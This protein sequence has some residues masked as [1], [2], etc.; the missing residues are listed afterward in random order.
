MDA[1]AMSP[2][3]TGATPT[4]P[5]LFRAAAAA[6][7]TADAVYA[8]D[9]FRSWERWRTEADALTRFLQESGI[10]PGDV[11]AVH[12]PNCWEFLTI[13]IAVAAAGA[14]LLPL[15]MALGA[16]EI[17]ALLARTGAVAL[18]VDADR[19]RTL[20]PALT[21][22]F[23]SLRVTLV[24]GIGDSSSGFAST[25]E[26]GDGTTVDGRALD[27]VDTE[28]AGGCC[29]FEDVV[30][31]WTGVS[32]RPVDVRP[33]DR[34]VLVPSSGTTSLRPKI[35]VHTH[36]SLIANAVAVAADAVMRADDTL[37]AAGP[38]THAFGLL[39]VHLSLVAGCRQALLPG[40]DPSAA[41]RLAGRSAATVLFAAPAQ[42]RDLLREPDFGTGLREIRVSGAAV[43]ASLVIDA[44]RAFGTS[45][46]A[47]WGMSE[48]GAGLFT[49]PDDPDD[50]AARGVGRPVTGAQARVVTADGAVC[51]PGETGELQFRSDFRCREYLGD[52]ELTRAALT[53]DGW[54]RTGDRATAHPDGSITLRGRDAEVINVGGQKFV[55]PEVETLLDD[56]PDLDRVAIIGRPDDRLGEY[57]CLVA[58]LRSPGA[59]VTLAGIAAHLTAKGV[60][61]YRIPAELVILDRLPYTPTGK[62]ARARL[63]EQLEHRTA[64]A[65]SIW[66]RELGTLRPA[67]RRSRALELVRA[68]ARAVV[69]AADQIAPDRVFTDYGLTSAGAVRLGTAL[70]AATGL[71]ITTTAAYDH[72]TP[73]LLAAHLTIL[74]DSPNSAAVL[75]GSAAARLGSFVDET[76]VGPEPVAVSHESAGAAQKP[77]AGESVPVVP[78][79]GVVVHDSART[80]L[81]AAADDPVVVIGI[82]CRVPGGVSSPDEFWE[83]LAAGRETIGD[84]PDDRGW[85]VDPDARYARRGSFL[86]ATRFDPGFFGISPREAATMDPQQR[87]LLETSWEAIEH[88]RI[89]PVS[90]RGSDTGVFAGVMTS[91]YLPRSYEVVTGSDPGMMTGN[92]GG[93]ASGRIAYVL[94]LHG[95]AI[96]VDTACSSGL[97]ALHLAVRSLRY[98]ECTL[99][100]AAGAAVL[101]TPV[102]F[103][104][105]AQ[106]N[107]LAADG[108]CK[109]F[110][111]A[112]D[113]TGWG[114]GVGVLVL[115]RLSVARQA[116]HRI[117]GIVRGSA[118]NSDGTSNGLTAP[119]GPAQQR[120]IHR[121]LAD[122]GLTTADVDVLEAHG[123]GTTLGDPIEANAVLATYGRDRAQPLLL[124]SL[125]SNIGH[126]QAAAGILGTIKMLLALHHR[127]VP[128]TLHVDSATPHAHWAAGSVRLATTAT[129]WPAAARPARASVSAFGI[130]GT[131][132]HVVLEAAPATLVPVPATSAPVTD[133]TAPVTDG[134][135]PAGGGAAPASG[136]AEPAGGGTASSAGGTALANGG[137]AP[138]RGAA[139]SAA[140]VAEGPTGIADPANPLLPL[141]VSAASPA[142]LAA[143]ADRI[144]AL[145]DTGAAAVDIGWSLA[146]TRTGF[147]HRAV[148]FGADRADLAALAAG[149]TGYAVTGRADVR[150]G[151]VFVCPGHGTQWAGMASALSVESPVFAA[152][153]DECE[154]AIRELA[155][156]S[157]AEVL[158]DESALSRTEF[159]QPAVFAITVAL[160]RLWQW[161]GVE[162]DAVI[163]HSFGEIA[164]AHLAGVLS[165][166]EAI[167]VVVRRGAACAGLSGRMLSVQSPV[168]EVEQRLAG[169]PGITVAARNSDRV[170]VVSGAAAEIEALLVEYRQAGVVVHPVAI[171]FASHSAHVE[172]A[173]DRLL[174]ELAGLRPRPARIPWYSTVTGSV[175]AGPEADGAYWYDNLRNPV[176]F[177][178]TVETSAAGGFRCFVEVSPHPV[179]ATA[180]A[181]TVGEA[182][183][184]LPTL[185]RRRGGTEQFANG[186]A[187]GYVRGL[188]VRWDRCFGDARTIDLPTY[189][190][191]RDRYWLTPPRITRA[192]AESGPVPSAEGT[193]GAFRTE[194][195]HLDLTDRRG[196]L[197]DLIR[198][199]AATL[200]GHPDPAAIEPGHRFT[201]IGFDSLTAME[202]HDSINRITGL[203]LPL[204]T[205]F[206]ADTPES[207]A[208]L[209]LSELGDGIGSAAH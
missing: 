83:L 143:Q 74:L 205:I 111:A 202:L 100:L 13:H 165:L 3:V 41:R 30:R 23:D 20:L 37:I 207:L 107:G 110:A 184:V 40:W 16:Y 116:G 18:A 183:Q 131:N 89:D 169:R 189:P 124:G 201:D 191:Q 170:T 209:L 6:G 161:Y 172:P 140:S 76:P 95:P 73:A 123:T 102:A 35:C 125:K 43:P 135:A 180:I 171:D 92:A 176:R 206:E 33:G 119:S 117:L 152:V 53:A 163:G 151:I 113:G 104:E 108:R 106:Q 198:T 45:V 58:T 54:L 153:L 8:G 118:V 2:I 15:P 192:A 158:D 68:Q 55:A 24:A 144:G 186:L 88:A 204:T 11:V 137:A 120:V 190:F 178:D 139:G 64:Q 146:T 9:G 1:T 193:A 63:A 109:P 122:A 78:A 65:D 71:P 27:G 94:D 182:G 105:F 42:V 82:G 29:T 28:S 97:V 72:P 34:F 44:R 175:L 195:A 159:V 98:G 150:G 79:S 145:L 203:A 174:A 52:P 80:A 14:V 142:G 5:A 60:A 129:P 162:P 32:P 81:G 132:A 166:R 155:G 173:R 66:T 50:A 115:E 197:E 160:A 167:G 147:E 103:A 177:A 26:S 126:T 187:R 25:G 12:L 114:E 96:T 49:R 112:A 36:D 61:S 138:A 84:F 17:R 91:D 21:A 4:L 62:I 47:Q 194:F 130:S 148:V 69:G 157:L 127:L 181:A 57:P 7:G 208:A 90:L 134:V 156:W 70:A 99:A 199:R 179:L 164:A 39:S 77:V 46:I 133:T 10:G 121:A 188:P 185:R 86:D 87:L 101:S 149:R 48:V 75:H 93:V 196:L 67:E 19:H 59:A 31:R 51:G 200:L 141:I 56:F 38:L 136:G 154:A 85:T 168:S 22:E 128:P